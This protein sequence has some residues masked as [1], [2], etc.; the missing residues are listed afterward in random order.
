MQGTSMTGFNTFFFC[1]PHL[2]WA[3]G[4]LGRVEGSQ[5]IYI[6]PRQT[7]SALCL[8]RTGGGRSLQPETC[9]AEGQGG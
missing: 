4:L 7:L 9:T 8:G 5:S 2:A 3:L 6:N 1:L